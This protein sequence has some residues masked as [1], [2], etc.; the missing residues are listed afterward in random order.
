M[1]VGLCDSGLGGL[2]VLKELRKKYPKNDYIYIGDNKNIPYYQTFRRI[3]LHYFEG[4]KDCP[5][6]NISFCGEIRFVLY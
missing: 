6:M 5:K 4:E 3:I 2:T 1:R